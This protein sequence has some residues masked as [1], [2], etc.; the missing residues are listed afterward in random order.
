M[1]FLDYCGW[2]TKS[3]QR[4]YQAKYLPGKSIVG[5]QKSLIFSFFEKLINQTNLKQLSAYAQMHRTNT[6][7]WPTGNLPILQLIS[8]S[9]ILNA[10]ELFNSN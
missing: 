1:P 9:S 4:Q 2:A 6:K 10:N 7:T 5:I 8:N 3:S